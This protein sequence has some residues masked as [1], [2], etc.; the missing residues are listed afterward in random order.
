MQGTLITAPAEFGVTFDLR[1]TCA[2][3]RTI[4]NVFLFLM[5][6][7]FILDRHF[8]KLPS[9]LLKNCVSTFIYFC[10]KQANKICTLLSSHFRALK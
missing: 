8:L 2:A 7:Y 3:K 10:I 5:A 1:F 9:A 6:K 4:E